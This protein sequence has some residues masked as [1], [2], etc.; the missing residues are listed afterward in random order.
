[1]ETTCMACGRDCPG[2]RSLPA[3]AEFDGAAG[4]EAV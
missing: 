4:Q 2:V 1:M 3:Q